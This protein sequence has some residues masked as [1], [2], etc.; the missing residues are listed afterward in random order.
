MAQDEMETTLAKPGVHE[1]ISAGAAIVRE[2]F[3]NRMNRL[4]ASSCWSAASAI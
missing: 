4:L 3:T 2:S 1:H